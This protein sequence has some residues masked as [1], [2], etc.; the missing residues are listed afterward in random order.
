MHAADVL[1]LCVEVYTTG[2]GGA[3]LLSAGLVV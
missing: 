3:V 2:K 1:T